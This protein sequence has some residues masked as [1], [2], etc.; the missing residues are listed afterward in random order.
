M[1]PPGVYDH[2]LPAPK[3]RNVAPAPRKSRYSTEFGICA[4]FVSVNVF[5]G[6]GAF[7][8]SRRDCRKPTASISG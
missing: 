4:F 7:V 6:S 5:E 8:V 2:Q 3:N 1:G